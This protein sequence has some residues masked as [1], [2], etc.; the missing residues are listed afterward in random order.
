MVDP[1]IKSALNWWFK[2]VAFFSFAAF[3]GILVFIRT[4]VSAGVF[5]SS[6]YLYAGVTGV[7][8]LVGLFWLECIYGLKK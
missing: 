4:G 3:L 1:V 2:I 6:A 8:M 7:L 5:T